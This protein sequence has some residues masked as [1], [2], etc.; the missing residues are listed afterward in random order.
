MH[1]RPERLDNKVP[2]LSLAGRSSVRS[3]GYGQ[4][5][6]VAEGGFFNALPKK[7]HCHSVQ[8]PLMLTRRD[9]CH[10]HSAGSVTW[11]QLLRW[12]HCMRLS[13]DNDDMEA[14]P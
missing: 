1:G 12:F 2:R 8:S 7:D 4:D 3:A 9:H 5:L 13:I 6:W 14:A 11:V 10:L